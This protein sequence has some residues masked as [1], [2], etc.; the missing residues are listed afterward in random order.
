MIGPM[1]SVMNGKVLMAGGAHEQWGANNCGPLKPGAVYDLN[2]QEWVETGPLVHP[3]GA[4]IA[5]RLMNGKVLITGGYNC[6]T[7]GSLSSA[8]LYTPPTAT[9]FVSMGDINKDGTPEIAVITHDAATQT[10]IARIKDAKTG[11]LVKRM[12]FNGHFVPQTASVVNDLNGNSAP[13][14]ALLGVRDSDQAVLVEV[15]DSLSG[16]G[17]RS[18]LFP[19]TLPPFDLAIVPEVNGKNTA[20]LAVL[21]QNDTTLRVQ[22]K[23]AFSGAGIL[24]I[25]FSARYDGVNLQVL[26]DLNGNGKP[27]L[28]V[29]G[30]N[31]ATTRPDAIEI[32]DSSSGD[33]IR[34]INL[35]RGPTPQQLFSLPDLNSN[36][37]QELAVLRTVAGG[38]EV[39]DSQVGLPFNMLNYRVSQPYRLAGVTDAG[40]NTDLA[41]LGERA[42]DGQNRAV[43]HDV[44]TDWHV[45]TVVY[46]PRGV[47]VGFISI[48]DIN[49]N[50]V[51]EL[52]RLRQQS[53]VHP[54]VAE[55]RDG[56][57]GELLKSIGF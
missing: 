37:G 36:G 2:T 24:A 49:G 32:R 11:L 16:V 48:P 27:E 3:R 47:N 54:F 20:G 41:L 55:V 43:V 21:Q 51:S 14:I 45:K 53:G 19:A 33:L 57:T 7:S 18:S 40:G 39:M 10:T 42:A 17:I 56:K 12:P 50:G 29:L 31:K 26:S 44:L 1:V 22:L 30:H 28:A 5:I 35:G 52:V 38:V 34:L 9:P 46:D 25:R 23:D 15:R 13:E 6:T 8:E 4:H